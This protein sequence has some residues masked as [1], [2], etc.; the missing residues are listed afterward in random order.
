MEKTRLFMSA[1]LILALL[2][3]SL[4]ATAETAL[5]PGVTA[6]MTDPA[7]WAEKA[8]KPDAVLADASGIEALN[9]AFLAEEA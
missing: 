1:L 2:L 6:G 3:A 8:D 7:Y 5:L 4:A 9:A